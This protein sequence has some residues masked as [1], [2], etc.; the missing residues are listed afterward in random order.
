M[1]R[2][3][4]IVPTYNR[5]HL[6]G[7]ALDSIF[8]QSYR[9][10]EILVVDDGSTDDTRSVVEA[11]GGVRYLAQENGGP[12]RARNFGIQHAQG[13]LI[14][15]LD[16]D[17]L[18]LTDFLE[19]Q[20]RV[21]DDHPE[22]ALASA[23]FSVGGREARFF[24]RSQ[25]LIAGDLYPR[26][27]RESFMRTPCTVV[28]RSCLD[29]VGGFNEAYRWSED[30]DL[31]LRIARRYPVAYVNRT[32][33]RIGRDGDNTSRDV[34]RPLDVHLKIALE[35]LDQNYD[36]ARIPRSVY[37]ERRA[38]RYLQFSRLYFLRGDGAGG[39]SCLRRAIAANPRAAR[40]YRY[41]LEALV[42]SVA[43]RWSG[44]RP[45]RRGGNFA[46]KAHSK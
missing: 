3:S 15:F 1:P 11:L 10:F 13:E 20:V 14:A 33:V 17:D 5:R 31:W 23:R 41:F 38:K 24:S 12:A 37:R 19:T 30:Q 45:W 7:R 25:T 36:P 34:K 35:V 27:Y 46:R 8:R 6:I 40:P 18:W 9:D 16:S 29:T 44:A 26:L 28:R 43:R 42:G 22:A 32:L 2:V 4:V 39:W 21:L